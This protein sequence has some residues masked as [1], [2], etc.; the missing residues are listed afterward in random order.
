ML[1]G[2]WHDAL[3]SPPSTLTRTAATAGASASHDSHPYRVRSQI[4]SRAYRT[5]SVS[6]LG[7]HPASSVQ[8]SLR[9]SPSRLPAS[10]QC[11]PSTAR[12]RLDENVVSFRA[13][14]PETLRPAGR[15]LD[16]TLGPW[17]TA[18]SAW[19]M[20]VINPIAI[21]MVSLSSSAFLVYLIR[22]QLSIISP[23]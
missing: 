9:Q 10:N 11:E 4:S 13:P 21:H 7:H 1:M 2:T 12:A 16:R 8:S 5:A 23:P 18:N 6:C 3:I 15:Y 22:V 14:G 20:S 19:R 17:T